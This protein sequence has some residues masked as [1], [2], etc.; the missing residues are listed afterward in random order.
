MEF[1]NFCKQR[2]HAGLPDKKWGLLPKSFTD[3]DFRDLRS[4]LSRQDVMTEAVNKNVIGKNLD[5]DEIW[6]KD[7]TEKNLDGSV[8][9]LIKFKDAVPFILLGFFCHIT[10]EVE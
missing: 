8:I 4:F 5:A 3:A 1:T 9:K 10:L 7:S 6:K 2:F